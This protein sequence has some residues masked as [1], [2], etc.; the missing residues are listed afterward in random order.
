MKHFPQT[1][2][3]NKTPR[4]LLN[5][6]HPYL[7]L[8]FLSLTCVS[9]TKKDTLPNDETISNSNSAIFFK[10]AIPLSSS[11]NLVLNDAK[12]KMN[13][14]QIKQFIQKA[15]F[16]TWDKANAYILP[17]LGST[18]RSA[19][20][21]ADSIVVL[22]VAL[23]NTQ[24]IHAAI[25][26]RLYNNGDS[27]VYSTHFKTH[28]AAI[29]ATPLPSYNL[30]ARDM[31]ILGMAQLDA[32]VFGHK[33]FI[34]S[35]E[36]V[37]F[38]QQVR[39]TINPRG[40][41]SVSIEGPT[42]CNYTFTYSSAYVFPPVTVWSYAAPCGSAVV[43][44]P[45]SFLQGLDA[46]YGLVSYSAAPVGEGS[47]SGSN[48]YSLE[49]SYFYQTLNAAQQAFLQ[50]QEFHEYYHGFIDYLI[51]HQFSE[52]AKAKVVWSI[53]YL[54]SPT[55]LMTSFADFYATY[56][57]DFP[58][59]AFLSQDDI[60]WI[61]NFPYLKSRIYYYLQQPNVLNKE[62]KVQYH[63]NRLRADV[64][65]LYFNI[66]YANNNQYNSLWFNDAIFLANFGG[67]P[68]GEWAINYLMQ[69]PPVTFQVFQNQFMSTKEGKDGDFD[70]N[71][72]NDLNLTFPTQNLPSWSAFSSNYP[73]HQDPLY[74]TPEKLYT[75]IGG[76][77]LLAYNSSPPDYQNTCALRISKALNYS[78]VTIPG[79]GIAIRVLTASFTFL[80]QQLY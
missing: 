24:A 14:E 22:P 54:T 77:V 47:G 64:E 78:G 52:E 4:I 67:S 15:G 40:L 29:A 2:E 25:V 35:D 37:R 8:F 43:M 26:A 18:Q 63:I 70:A 30:T 50:N 55:T 5:I 38:G 74:D 32:E 61:N 51:L 57:N 28:F 44:P 68:F 65:Y 45:A 80:V 11:V 17:Q 19:G 69:H 12:R 48:P 60:N 7:Y 39:S 9:W 33:K 10:H 21:T 62:A 79:G 46:T 16:I 58:S 66:D 6:K 49:F 72:W 73:K 20:N 36:D 71:Y 31:Y 59:L 27:I 42:M 76:Q 13:D 1:L 41:A 53:N 23:P 75:A 56:L 3:F 34:V